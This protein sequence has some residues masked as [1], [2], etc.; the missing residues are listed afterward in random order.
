MFKPH[1]LRLWSLALA[2]L[3]CTGGLAVRSAR[4][5]EAWPSKRVVVI[6]G[7]AAGGFAD[8]VARI[9]SRGL[10]DRWKQAVVVQNMAGAGGNTAARS[11]SGAAPDGYTLLVTTTS[12][13]INETLYK[14]KGFSSA[15]LTAIAI[16]VEAPEMIAANPKTGIKT[17][18]DMI[19]AATAGK[20]YLGSSGIGTGSHIVAEYFLRMRA[21]VP[22]THIPFQGGNPAM[23]ALLNGDVNLMASTATA[24]QGVQSGE[25]VGLAVAAAQRNPIVPSVPTYAE[26][27]FPG[28][29]ASSWAGFFAPTGTPDSVLSLI[30]RDIGDLLQD[31]DKRRQF[32]T[33]GVLTTVR[34]RSDTAAFMAQ[35]IP[36][37]AEMVGA[38]GLRSE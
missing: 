5:Q 15:G 3:V 30:N 34:S 17:F 9:I 24:I 35:E 19:A 38:L 28:F 4:A 6:V 13:A 18:A 16:P 2:F 26:Q 31:A 7:F 27:G 29:E 20:L 14:D 8:N 22:V 23:L 33:M 10:A 21:K 25:L 36:R 11:V 37:W 32:E 12:L 1:R